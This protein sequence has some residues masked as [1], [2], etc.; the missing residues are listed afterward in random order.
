[1]QAASTRPHGEPIDATPQAQ[2]LELHADLIGRIRLGFGLASQTFEDDIRPLLQRY[3]AC[4]HRQPATARDYHREP[5]GL[6]RL[7]LE[8][9]FYSLQGTDAHIFSGRAPIAQRRQL[10]PRWRVATFV[11]GLCVELHRIAAD[12]QI[13]APTGERWS[14]FV[15][16]LATWLHRNRIALYT[17]QWRATSQATRSG[18]LLLLHHVVPATLLQWLSE[19]NDVILPHLLASLGGPGTDEPNV[20]DKVVRRA[21]A[22]VVDHTPGQAPAVRPAIVRAARPIADV[23]AQLV[24]D[25]PH[26]TPNLAKSRLWRGRDGTFL[27][28]PQGAHDLLQALDDAPD[29]PNT[30]CELIAALARAGLLAEPDPCAITPPGG[31]PL[32]ALHL[33]DEVLASTGATPA[34]A[35]DE[36]LRAASSTAASPPDQLLLFERIGDESS[37]PATNSNHAAPA[38]TRAPPPCTFK[39]PLRLHPVVR[40][41]LA[42]IVQ[43]LNEP[44][45]MAWTVPEGLFVP[46]DALEQRG[47][48]SAV[49]QR[50]LAA[51][52]LLAASAQPRTLTRTGA[53]STTGLVLDPRCITGW[54]LESLLAPPGA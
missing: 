54:D 36:D 11:A 48:P 28:W 18:G 9:A 21:H 35:L 20:L 27:V 4:V 6:L 47:V 19:D 2:L 29:R 7:G 16:P 34:A 32:T 51:V 26:W 5:G 30:P 38:A 43:S 46:F 39:A 49:A 42:A 12:R 44:A 14:P 37:A 41:A 3:A 13:T 31:A 24:R 10:E 1:M 25:H 33:H 45:A 40:D 22:L 50:S 8:V 23:I 53:P 17:V 15:E 52:G